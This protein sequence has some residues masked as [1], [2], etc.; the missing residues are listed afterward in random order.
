MTVLTNICSVRVAAKPISIAELD[1][2]DLA[3]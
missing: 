1:P 3:E 2:A